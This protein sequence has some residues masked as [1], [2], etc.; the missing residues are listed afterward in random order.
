MSVR[1]AAPGLRKKLLSLLCLF[2]VLA[3]IL[4]LS[5]PVE[6]DAAS[7]YKVKQWKYG[8]TQ[9]YYVYQ[10]NPRRD[11]MDWP[12][13][14]RDSSHVYKSANGMK[15]SFYEP[16][17]F[18]TEEKA[19]AFWRFLGSHSKASYWYCGNYWFDVHLGG[20]SHR[21]YYAYKI[22]G[23][24]YRGDIGDLLAASPFTNSY[25]D[26]LYVRYI[27]KGDVVSSQWSYI[28]KTL[29]C[30]IGLHLNTPKPKNGVTV[31]LEF[32]SLYGETFLNY[33]P[34]V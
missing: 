14:W 27:D 25:G 33:C 4:P 13:F 30:S 31:A 1:S 28:R 32:R 6:A 8:D 15:I 2:L 16:D 10:G 26:K 3:M 19:D 21:Y 20:D 11:Y 5:V 29:G 22:E 23:W 34:I 17:S 9:Y 7:S 12:T 18:V 24:N